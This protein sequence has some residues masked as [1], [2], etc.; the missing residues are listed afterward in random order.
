M[1]LSPELQEVYANGSPTVR[2][3]ET[4]ELQHH[5]FTGA[6]RIVND[7]QPW[8]LQIE[9]NSTPVR[10]E[11]FPFSVVD[12][13]QNS[14]GVQ[15]LQLSIDNVD[16][17]MIEKL[18]GT[19]DGL[20]VPIKLVYRV[21]LSNDNTGPQNDP[22]LTLEIRQIAVDNLKVTATAT[23]DNLQNKGFPNQSYDRVFNTLV[24]NE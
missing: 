18:E 24:A 21:Y 7:V 4:L 1:T 3:L 17:S 14:R 5:T 6:F 15:S 22:P 12:P 2:V 16:G 10:F 9:T 20:N 11:T 13:Q 8:W 23:N 19:Q